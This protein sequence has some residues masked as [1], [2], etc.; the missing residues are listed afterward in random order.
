MVRKHSLQ[1]IL[2]VSV[3]FGSYETFCQKFLFLDHVNDFNFVYLEFHPFLDLVPI[4]GA[5]TSEKVTHSSP[6]CVPSKLIT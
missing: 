6:Y 1:V 5:R 4:N 2:S 3:I